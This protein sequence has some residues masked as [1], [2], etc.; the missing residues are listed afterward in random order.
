MFD[1]LGDGIRKVAGGVG[2]IVAAPFD[3]VADALDD[4]DS[5]KREEQ[6]RRERREQERRERT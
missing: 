1:S 4:E 6:L 2:D 5:R 3:M